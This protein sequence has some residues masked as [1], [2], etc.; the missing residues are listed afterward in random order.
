MTLRVPTYGRTGRPFLTH[1][2]R[3]CVGETTPAE[4]QD[5]RWTRG[6]EVDQATL[7]LGWR[8]RPKRRPPNGA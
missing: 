8:L 7:S 1:T 6:L 3:W 2:K 5:D 4:A